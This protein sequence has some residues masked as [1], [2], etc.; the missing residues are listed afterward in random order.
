MTALST[1]TSIIYNIGSSLVGGFHLTLTD[2]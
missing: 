1:L 2:D